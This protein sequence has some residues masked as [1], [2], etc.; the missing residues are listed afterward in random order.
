ME[1]V[2]TK[3]GALEGITYVRNHENGSLMECTLDKLNKLDTPYG[4]LIPKYQYGEERSKHIPS[5]AFYDNGNL[6]KIY[7]QEQTSV[8]T[9]IGV[10]PA[11]FITFYKNGSI[12]RIF[13]L[14]G[15]IT[16]YW[17]EKDE[18]DLAEELE[19][20]LPTGNLKEKIISAHFYEGGNIKS[21]TF[22]NRNDVE[23][24]SPL[25]NVS[26]RIG[27]SF[28]EDGKL[29]SF[30]PS[31]PIAVLTEIGTITAYNK[32]AVGIHGDLNSIKFSKNGKVEALV[33]STDSIEVVHIKGERKLYKPLLKQSIINENFMEVVPLNIEFCGDKVRFSSGMHHKFPAEYT[34]EQCDFH[35]KSIPF[36]TER[37]ECSHPL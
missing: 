24:S 3:Y 35:V 18:Y 26:V 25:G 20:Q 6:K 7:L 30:E 34:L 15:R 5:A 37:A 36:D 28:Y 13:P 8:K 33:T 16:G 22:W 4:L 19:I 32:E 27:V 29:K 10:L 31:K 21:I 23:I 11:E 2:N 9:S 12:N 17:S 1:Q 14:N